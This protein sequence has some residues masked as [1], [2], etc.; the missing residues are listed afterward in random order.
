MNNNPIVS[1]VMPVYNAE[2]YL[3]EAIESILNQ[4]Y[5][6]FEFI[7]INDGSTDKSLEIIEK[8]KNQDERIVL[9]SR[10]NRGLIASLNEGIEKAKGKYI[11][12][13]DADDISL[14]ERFEKQLELM[15]KENIDICGCHY[16]MIN[17]YGKYIDMVYVPLDNLSLLLYLILA[18]PFA[19]G[20]VMMRK[21]FLDNKNLE[22]GQKAD[23]AEDKALWIQMYEFNAKFG[24]VNEVL[25]EYREF[26]Q[27]LSKIRAKKLKLEDKNL[28]DFFIGDHLSSIL[29][30]IDLLSNDIEKLSNRELEHLAD[31]SIILFFKYREMKYWKIFNKVSS[32]YKVIAIFKY[33]SK[34]F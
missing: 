34:V 20:S 27:S 5:K 26:S 21:S 31:L 19:H 11:A 8:Y 16:S 7:I 4:T 25:F 15:E 29:E 13:M 33:L 24:N 32:R 30:A 3:D 10:E 17:K 9:I 6:D 1:V 22:Y 2:K 14:P 28:K 23:F 18:V 12:R